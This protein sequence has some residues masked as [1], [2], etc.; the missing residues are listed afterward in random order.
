MPKRNVLDA[1]MTRVKSTEVPKNIYGWLSIRWRLLEE[2]LLDLTL[3]LI[4]ISSAA[5]LKKSRTDPPHKHRIWEK[6]K[7][8]IV[9]EIVTAHQIGKYNQP[10]TVKVCWRSWKAFSYSP[11]REWQ[12]SDQD[13]SLSRSGSPAG[14]FREWR[15]NCR[16]MAIVMLSW[17][18]GRQNAS[19]GMASPYA[20]ANTGTLGRTTLTWDANA[21]LTVWPKVSV[22]DGQTNR[23]ATAYT[24]VS[25]SPL[26]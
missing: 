13:L 26:W 22:N 25:A 3:T 4:I 21:S 23:S 7:K 5:D 2:K 18:S 19:L 20:S 1:Y 9:V 14:S 8:E 12:A 16:E 11:T 6:M 24:D 10:K 15:A 17:Q